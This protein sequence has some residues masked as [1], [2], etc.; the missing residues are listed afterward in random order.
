MPV[1][2][3]PSHWPFSQRFPLTLGAVQTRSLS[4]L[5]HG[6]VRDTRDLAASESVYPGPDPVRPLNPLPVRLRLSSALETG[7]TVGVQGGM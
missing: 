1:S 3:D 4:C 2:R 6:H 5:C 7:A